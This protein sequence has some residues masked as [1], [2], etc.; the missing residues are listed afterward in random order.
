MND[1]RADAH[2]LDR[3]IGTSDVDVDT[4]RAATDPA[5]ANMVGPY[6]GATAATVVAA[7]ERD[8]RV[9]GRPVALTLNYAAPVADGSYELHRTPV[10]TNNSNQ[11]WTCTVEQNGSTVLTGSALTAVERGGWTDLEVTG[12]VAPAPAEVPV[13]KPVRGLAW[14]DNYEMRFVTGAFPVDGAEAS[15]DSTTTVWVRHARPR[16][17]DYPALASACDIF[18]PRI[19]NRLGR[20]VPAGTVTLTSYFHAGPDVLA[21]QGEYLLCTVR[22][23]QFFSGLADQRAQIWGADGSLLATTTQLCYYKA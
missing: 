10:R 14:L 20:A 21:E 3:V 16:G 2:P 12:P 5:F 7:I 13:A 8:Q 9:H 6:G 22:A 19:F 4:V 17:W 15:P 18:G 11:H 23:T 1:A